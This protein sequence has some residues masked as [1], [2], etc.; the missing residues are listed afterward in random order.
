MSDLTEKEL[1][2]RLDTMLIRTCVGDD[3]E[4][5]EEIREAYIQLVKI[6]EEYFD[7]IEFAIEHKANIERLKQKQADTEPVQV[8][9]DKLDSAEIQILSQPIPDI[10]LT[11]KRTM[12]SC[13]V[14][15]FCHNL[16]EA[17]DIERED[18]IAIEVELTKWLKELD[19]EVV[20]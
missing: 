4:F 5:L 7:G 20:E 11:Q 8:D 3:E 14:H 10:T 16:L 15:E 19:I 13:K 9:E 6:V 17:C 1:I 2:D 12:T 18:M